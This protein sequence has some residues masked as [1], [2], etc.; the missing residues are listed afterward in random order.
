MEIFRIY[1]CDHGHQWALRAEHDASEEV[2]PRCP[3]GHEAVTCRVEEPVDD[4]QIV[5][6]PAARVSDRRT[7]HRVLEGRYRVALLDRESIELCCSDRDYSWDEAAQ[8]AL[9]FI[10]KDKEAALK[11]WGRKNP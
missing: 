1:R 7:G 5:F 8:L 2:A 9:L 3:E 11:W 4:V 6:R 10:G